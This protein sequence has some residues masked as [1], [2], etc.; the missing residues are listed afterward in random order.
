MS[1]YSD[2]SA[3]TKY[4]DPKIYVPNV[5]A[6]WELDSNEAAYLPDLRICFLGGVTD[7]K[8]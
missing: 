7:G 1:Y 5:R 2:D 3:S 4:I 6:S 8:F